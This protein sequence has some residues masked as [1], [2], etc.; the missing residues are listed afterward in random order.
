MF[1]TDAALHIAKQKRLSLRGLN[2]RP[3]APLQ[4]P[5]PV[6]TAHHSFA[7]D[8]Q[9]RIGVNSPTCS[10]KIILTKLR[11][12]APNDTHIYWRTLSSYRM[13]EMIYEHWHRYLIVRNY[14]AG[15][16]RT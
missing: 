16:T 13:R 6:G 11:R 14:V 7:G 2:S 10:P 4:T 12:A 1:V 15:K 9:S 5:Q 3:F 8:R